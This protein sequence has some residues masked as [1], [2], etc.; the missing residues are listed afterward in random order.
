MFDAQ[1]RYDMQDSYYEPEHECS[2]C[3]KKEIKIE[4]VTQ[5]M[6]EVVKQIYSKSTLDVGVLE[7]CLDELCHFFKVRPYVN[8]E[9]PEIQ[10]KKQYN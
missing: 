2:D 10:R 3:V 7:H 1:Y 8:A 5:Y 9:G 4:D 6:Q